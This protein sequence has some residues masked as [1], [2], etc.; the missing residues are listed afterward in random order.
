MSVNEIG[1]G[2][3][4]PYTF[5]P[6]WALQENV[7]L[8]A[9]KF[10]LNVHVNQDMSFMDRLIMLNLLPLEYL[11]SNY[12]WIYYFFSSNSRND[13]ISTDIENYLNTFEPRFCTRKYV[14]NN[15]NNLI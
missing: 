3:T 1:R 15:N 14:N 8:K 6:D 13:L 9:I 10:E 11:N 5:K 2:L 12:F 7:K 4:K